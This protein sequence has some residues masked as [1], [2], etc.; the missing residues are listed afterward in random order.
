MQ[1]YAQQN[2]R[3]TIDMTLTENPLGCSPRALQTLKTIT[4]KDIST[5]QTTNALQALLANKLQCT[6]DQVLI[7]AGSEPIIRLICEIIAPR[8]NQLVIQNASF[9]VFTREALRQNIQITYKQIDELCD[10]KTKDSLIILCSPNN[11][12]GKVIS[13]DTLEAI[14]NCN[15]NSI[16]VI[17]EAN[18]E[19]ANT[20]SL[21]LA[22]KYNN[23]M[24]I[25]T[26]S[27]GYGLS[28][29][30]VGYCVGNSSIISQLKKEQLS[31]PVSS[32]S[33][34][35]AER[36]VSDILFLKKT[37]EFI[38]KERDIL[39]TKIQSLGLSVSNS[40]TSNLYVYAKRA[41]TIIKLLQKRNVSVI[42]GSYFPGM[43]QPGF[44]IS[45]RDKQTNAR[46]ITALTN[47]LSCINK[48]E[49]IPSKEVI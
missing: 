30:R 8:L 45:I 26:L 3:G 43:N 37:Q 48:K 27:K 1:N 36:I 41:K 42:D 19:F 7:D 14:I 44:R 4:P 6:P 12:T 2:K 32:L 11:P 5:Y 38:K 21:P 10:E 24:V 35:I 9:D 40:Q 29:L 20:T 49:L 47:V 33:L 13:Q 39:T 25:K 31:F 17:D 23:V 34:Y 46:F 18:A 22:S 28:G 15:P 16:I